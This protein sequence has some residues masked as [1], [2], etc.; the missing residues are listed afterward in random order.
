MGRMSKYKRSGSPGG[1]AVFLQDGSGKLVEQAPDASG[2]DLDD[3]SRYSLLDVDRDG[4]L[5][6]IA[7]TPDGARVLKNTKGQDNNW[8]MIDVLGDMDGVAADAL[9]TR[10]ELVIGDQHITREVQGGGHDGMS[11]TRSLHFGLGDAEA[12]DEVIVTWPNGNKQT[13]PGSSVLLK[14]PLV[15]DSKGLHKGT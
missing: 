15:L 5:D 7:M 9:G 2:I 11:H 6:V 10:I 14:T 13:L 4:D 3:G 1:L 12:V 8:V